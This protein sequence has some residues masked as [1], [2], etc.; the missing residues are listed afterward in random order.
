MPILHQ[1]HM[2]GNCYKVRLVARQLG[3]YVHI[4][5]LAIRNVAENTK[6]MSF[7]LILNRHAGGLHMHHLAI[8]GQQPM[9]PGWGN[10]VFILTFFDPFS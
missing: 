7:T 2:S 10:P 8:Q 6:N 9:F 5:S 4:G 1:M 3:I